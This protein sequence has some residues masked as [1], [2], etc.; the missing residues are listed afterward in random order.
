MG[1]LDSLS[2]SVSSTYNDQKKSLIKPDHFDDYSLIVPGI[3][4]NDFEI[5]GSLSN[6]SIIMI[7]DNTSVIIY[8]QY[9][10]EN[11]ISMPGEYIYE[12]GSLS[13]FNGDGIMKSFFGNISERIGFSGNSPENKKICFVNTRVINNIKFGTS[14][15]I[16]IHNDEMD[17]DLEIVA[18]GSFSFQVIDV[19]KFITQF[20]PP[21]TLKLSVNDKYIKNELINL[22]QKQLL[23]SVG[24][25][26]R[27][28]L[29]T[30][31]A[32]NISQIETMLS[33]NINDY[34]FWK[35]KYGFIIPKI[36]IQ[37]VDYSEQ[38]KLFIKRYLEVKLAAKLES[39]RDKEKTNLQKRLYSSFDEQIE[40]VKKLKEL[41]DAGI[42]S[43]EEFEKKKAD[44]LGL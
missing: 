14:R 12:D 23:I 28:D 5:D 16:I 44:I 2:K 43:H 32:N 4:E 17:Y 6:G 40:A 22:L 8:G 10:V 15:P 35:D 41:E 36:T 42:L 19:L 20:V 11:C 31:L 13:V 26:D 7:P 25:L 37:N 24:S 29:A 30:D 38:S 18:Y 1:I 39:E 9:A 34:N 27:H 33:D 3:D 21:L